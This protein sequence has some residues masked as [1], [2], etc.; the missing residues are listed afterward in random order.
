MLNRKWEIRTHLCLPELALGQLHTTFA[1]FNKH[2]KSYFK[3]KHRRVCYP[4]TTTLVLWQQPS[5]T[6][7][8]AT[9]AKAFL[10]KH[11]VAEQ[12]LA[13]FY[14]EFLIFFP[15][16][17]RKKKSLISRTAQGTELL[18]LPECRHG[19]H[20]VPHHNTREGMTAKWANH[21]ASN[22][23]VGSWNG[24]PTRIS[25][26]ALSWPVEQK[27]RF[28]LPSKITAPYLGHKAWKSHSSGLRRTHI[29]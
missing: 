27:G 20:S 6:P 10:S 17:N 12:A 14:K 16:K 24:V 8:S 7:Q 9:M 23:P 22:W 15:I 26:R 3:L 25:A 19:S 1:I 5:T 4:Y 28:N 13:H 29:P 11:L 21:C 18:D 2:Y